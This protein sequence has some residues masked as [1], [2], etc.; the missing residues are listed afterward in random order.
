MPL[1]TIDTSSVTVLDCIGPAVNFAETVFATVIG[2]AV[3]TNPVDD[4]VPPF[5]VQVFTLLSFSHPLNVTF[6]PGI[7]VRETSH[8]KKLELLP[9]LLPK[10]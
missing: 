3:H 1:P 6:A 8:Q 5:E 4:T 9:M 7:A 2:I 10:P